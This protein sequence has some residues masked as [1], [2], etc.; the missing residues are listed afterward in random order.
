MVVIIV[1]TLVES[2]AAVINSNTNLSFTSIK[3]NFFSVVFPSLCVSLHSPTFV[4]S[5]DHRFI[6]AFALKQRKKSRKK[7]LPLTGDA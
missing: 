3:F 6:L 5:R 1:P 4:P 7:T 2:L